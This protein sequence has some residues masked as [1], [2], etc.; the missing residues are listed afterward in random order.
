MKIIVP[1]K[2]VLDPSGLTFR[3]DKERMFVNREEHIIGAGSKAAIEAALRLRGDQDRV[4]AI[5]MGKLQADDALREALAMGCDSAY[6]LS[7]K[8]F[9][10]ADISVTTRVLAA[11]IAEFGGADLVIT[12]RESDDTGAGQIGPRLAEALGYA[13]VTDI[14]ALAFE[15]EAIQATRRWGDGYATVRATLPAVI[16]VAPEA[17][18]PRYAHGARIINA[19]REWEVQVWNVDDLGLAE[20]A[21]TPLLAFRG[22][23]FPPPLEAEVFRGD[24][25]TLAQEAVMTLKLQKLIEG[26]GG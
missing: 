7:D 17:F 8:A 19:Y 21:L 22:E 24:P 25:D 18:P 16:T 2:Q 5:S 14:Y 11:A 15:G 26:A 1:I 12:G 23:G 9:T 20:A 3:R 13:Q 4:I 6:L 10:E